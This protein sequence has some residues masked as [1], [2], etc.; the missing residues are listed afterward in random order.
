MHK[1]V[2]AGD[3]AGGNPHRPRH[4]IDPHPPHR[5]QVADPSRR[6]RVQ[7]RFWPPTRM[8]IG[9]AA[10]NQQ[11]PY[12]DLISITNGRENC[13]NYLLL[14]AADVGT[15][16]SLGES[17]AYAPTTSYLPPQNG[18]ESQIAVKHSFNDFKPLFAATQSRLQRFAP[19]F[20]PTGASSRSRR[21]TRQLLNLAESE[22]G[23]LSSQC[24]DRRIPD[25]QVLTDEVAAWRHDRNKNHA[26]PD[27]RST[28]ANARIKFKR[29]YRGLSR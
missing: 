21:R 2:V 11:R 28:T 13:R 17:G 18:F 16:T 26:K 25:K 1:C 8:A 22:L 23:V 6:R 24:L 5:R 15:P 4:R 19:R 14:A 12:V 20:V 27:W 10:R 29:L 7:V 3:A 9:G